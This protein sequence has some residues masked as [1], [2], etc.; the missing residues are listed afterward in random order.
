MCETSEGMDT[1][2]M[3]RLDLIFQK[4]LSICDVAGLSAVSANI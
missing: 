4:S 3:G 1:S 2:C